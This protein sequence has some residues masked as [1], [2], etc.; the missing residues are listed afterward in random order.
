MTQHTPGPWEYR[1][2]F[3]DPEGSRALGLE[4]TRALDNEGSATVTAEDGPVARVLLQREDVKRQDK[5]KSDDAERDANAHLIAAAPLMLDTLKVVRKYLPVPVQDQ[6]DAVIA[7]AEGK[8][9]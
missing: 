1:P 4:P 3:G 9:P 2:Y 5:W 7:K 6:L 8:Q